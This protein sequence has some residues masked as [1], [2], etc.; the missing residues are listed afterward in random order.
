MRSK[1]RYAPEFDLPSGALAIIT[2][3]GKVGSRAELMVDVVMPTRNIVLTDSQDIF[4]G[5]LV[6]SGRYKSAS[7]VLREGL[8]LLEY[9]IE[10]RKAELED[11]RAGV[12]EGIRQAE[13]GDFA[14]GSAEEA[15]KRAFS[16]ARATH[17]S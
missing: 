10:R 7:E 5:R 14:E 6:E 8:R 15:V 11:I 17:R 1:D 2:I 12:L 4:V 16:R 3:F 13:A 9:D